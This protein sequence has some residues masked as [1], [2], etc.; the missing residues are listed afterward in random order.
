MR[1]EAVNGTRTI[2][3]RGPHPIQSAWGHAADPTRAPLRGWARQ[4]FGNRRLLAAVPRL[5][6]TGH[7]FSLARY[8]HAHGWDDAALAWCLGLDVGGLPRLALC[9][10]PCPF[11]PAYGLAVGRIA[12][13]VGGS[14]S[15]LLAVLREDWS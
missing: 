7:A 12:A 5:L 4:Q 15:S 9:R 3:S 10:R 6:H 11:S 13:H 14:A 8:R 2:D 1:E